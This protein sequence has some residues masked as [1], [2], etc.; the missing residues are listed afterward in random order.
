MTHESNNPCKQLVGKISHMSL[1]Q[2]SGVIQKA[3]AIGETLSKQFLVTFMYAAKPEQLIRKNVWELLS[4]PFFKY[5]VCRVAGSPHNVQWLAFN[6]FI[7]MKFFS[8]V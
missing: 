1:F 5:G 7:N 6:F 4:D 2:M 8:S 3:Y